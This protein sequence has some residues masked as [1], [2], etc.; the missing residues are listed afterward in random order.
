MPVREYVMQGNR[1]KRLKK[2]ATIGERQQTDEGGLKKQEKNLGINL[3][4]GY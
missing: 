2:I 4:R 1:N 3:S